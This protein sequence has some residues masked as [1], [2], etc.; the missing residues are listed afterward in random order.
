GT[1]GPQTVAE[2]ASLAFAVT[3][4]SLGAGATFGATNL[5]EGAVFDAATAVFRWMPGPDQAGDYPAIGFTASDGATTLPETVAI[6]VAE[7]KL[8]LGGTVRLGDGSPVPGAAIRARTAAGKWTAFSDANGRYRFTD[9][10]PR[11][12]TVRLD[13]PTKKFYVATPR[14]GV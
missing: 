5:P 13:K 12:Y 3:A 9:L 10:T 11:A 14:L 1:I 4:P 7:A 8:T 6:T 2:R